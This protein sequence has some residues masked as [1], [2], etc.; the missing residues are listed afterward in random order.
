MSEKILKSFLKKYEGIPR[1]DLPPKIID[2]YLDLSDI[3]LKY[4][5]LEQYKSDYKSAYEFFL[6]SLE[7]LKQ[8]DHPYS[9]AVAEVYY[10]MAN[11]ADYD[12]RLAMTCFY[13]TYLIMK[14][15]L[16]M[17]LKTEINI[18]IDFDNMNK[19]DLQL[20]NELLIVKPDDNDEI[21]DLKGIMTELKQ[22]VA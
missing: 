7:I 20:D 8:Y 1:A 9:R 5:E 10:L 6:S 2:Y 22:K 13:K 11:V 19:E 17:E 14:K 18:N 15:L 21:V 3:Y 16:M 4:G 12:A